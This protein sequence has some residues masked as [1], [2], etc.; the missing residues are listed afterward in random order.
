MTENYYTFFVISNIN[1]VHSVFDGDTRF[2]QTVE[3]LKSIRSRVKNARILFTDNSTA[4]LVDSQI[5]V[6]KPMVDMYVPYQNNLFNKYVNT[7]GKNKGLNEILVYENLLNVARNSG[8]IGR[9]IFKISGR[10]T[11]MD[12]FDICEYD[13]PGY[14]GKYVFRITPWVYNEGQGETVKYFY[15]TALWSMCGTL[16]PQY[17]LLLQEIFNH[18]MVTGENI[19]VSHNI[20]I[21]KDKLLIVPNVWG[22]GHM[23]GGE[24]TRF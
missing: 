7:L 16:A 13:K 17:R 19:E 24:Y 12:E 20:K 6:I 4:P 9:R 21:P 22:H 5:A 18:M 15:N 14:T 10:Y 2:M 23:A 8:M 1:T 3:T 11:L